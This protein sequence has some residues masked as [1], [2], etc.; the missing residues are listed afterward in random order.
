MMKNVWKS[1]V[2]GSA[3]IILLTVVAY[4]PALRSGFIWD[5][6]ELVVQNPLIRM[7]DGLHRF[8]FT[9]QPPD[10]WPLTSTTWWLEWRLWGKN[11][12]GYH[13][14]NVILHALSAVLWWRILTRLKIPGAWLAA[15]VF[16]VHPVNVESVAWIAERKNTLAMFLLALA[17]LWYLR[18]E[19][20]EQKG[21][22][23]GALGTFVLALLSK[24]AVAT[25]PV[26][27]LGTAWWRRGRIER[28]DVLRSLPFFVVAG[29][30]GCVT[31]WFQS[32][33]AVGGD[34]VR[35]DGF[36]S[37]LAGA[38]WAIWFYAYKAVVPLNLCFVYPRWRID[39]QNLF[40]YVPGLLVVAV[41]LVCWR[42]R[43]EWGK[44]CLLG[45]GYYLTMLMPALG[46]VNIYFMRYS[47]VADHWQYFSIIGLI[48]LV[49]GA[50]ATIAERGGAHR[51][52]M[53][54]SAGAVVLLLLAVMTWRQQHIYAD[55]ETLWRDTLAKNPECWFAHNNLSAVLTDK[56][57]LQESIWHCEQALRLNPN[58]AEPHNSF[59]L[60][61]A[62][63]GKPEDAIGQFLQALRIKPNYA[64]A[65]GNLGSVLV[66]S[67]R[68][69]EAIAHYEEALHLKPDLA[70]AHCDLG[71]ALAQLGRVQ[72]A[73]AHYEQALRINPGFAEA[74]VNL[75]SALLAQG[76]V[77]D[78]MAHYEEALRLKPD[79]AEAHMSLGSALLIQGQVP[80]AIG[81][82]EEALRLKPDSAE[83][84]D[85]LGIAL[86][87][88]RRLPEAMKH[89]E[90]ALKLKPDDVEAHMNLGKALQ[91]QGRVPEAI[92]HYQQALKLRPDFAP[93]KNAL[94]RLEGSQ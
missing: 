46:F 63:Q 2:A 31:V 61:L 48:A 35:Q 86:A 51:R 11:P 49:V 6:D 93:A 40:S 55:L 77:R 58:C 18:F 89:W 91:A 59:G 12:A 78:A 5:D 73:I 45:L 41:L 37:R 72:E 44:S 71:N 16:A 20:E 36:W 42:Y 76:D 79:N 24:T 17:G 68:I 28:R 60:A 54:V 56:G 85:N 39:P 87:Q 53:G 80:E 69:P 67:G 94:A 10:Y 13:M 65:H 92:Q 9:T 38:G 43:R 62:R 82:Y 74:H 19:D 75:G 29:V 25:L 90:E 14:V 7:S 70:M 30:L 88:A 84:H 52:N 1:L 34:I 26:V 21:W 15:A 64:E 3:L 32:Y 27:L 81:R 4:V 22:Y 66:Q 33:R 47:L 23:W 83:A 57:E 50:G 8:W